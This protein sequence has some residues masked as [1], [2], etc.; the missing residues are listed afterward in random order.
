LP[1][2]PSFT[3]SSVEVFPLELPR[4][5]PPKLIGRQWG[6]TYIIGDVYCFYNWD[7]TEAKNSN[8]APHFPSLLNTAMSFS[9]V[10]LKQNDFFFFSCEIRSFCL[11]EQNTFNL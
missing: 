6:F 5:L 11:V 3:C 1:Y 7:N 8:F 4:N 2:F 9:I 10:S